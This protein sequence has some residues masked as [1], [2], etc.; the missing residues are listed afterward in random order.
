MRGEKERRRKSFILFSIAHVGKDVKIR[1]NKLWLDQVV[2]SVT[3][4]AAKHAECEGK[5]ISVEER[6]NGRIQLENG[7]EFENPS[8]SHL[9]LDQ[10]QAKAEV[11]AEMEAEVKAQAKTEAIAKVR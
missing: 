4:D 1:G 10:A 11:E 3:W 9:D 2:Q 8:M 7:T 6:L 5:I